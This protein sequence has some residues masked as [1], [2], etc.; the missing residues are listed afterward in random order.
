MD[1]DLDSGGVPRNTW[2]QGFPTYDLEYADDT[3]IMAQTTLELQHMPAAVESV[4]K[5]Y[6]VQLNHVKTE[7]LIHAEH[8]SSPV[9]F[10]DGTPVPRKEVVKY[11]GCMIAWP[12]PF[13][14]ADKHRTALAEEAHKNTENDL[15]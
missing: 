12:N 2:S 3:P 1:E 9:H 8:P 4:A 13:D 6:G 14:V 11:L 5:E 15:E 7:M 10:I